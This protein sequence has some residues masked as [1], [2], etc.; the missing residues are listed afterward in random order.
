MDSFR[1]ASVRQA[2][3]RLRL[4]RAGPAGSRAKVQQQHARAAAALKAPQQAGDWPLSHLHNTSLSSQLMHG[5]AALV[6]LF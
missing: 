4:E 5:S 1:E 3:Q 6:K 2:W